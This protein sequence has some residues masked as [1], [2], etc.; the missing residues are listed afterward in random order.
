[1]P[2]LPRVTGRELA[3]ALGKLGWVVASPSLRKSGRRNF[4]PSP[5]RPDVKGAGPAA[6]LIGSSPAPGGTVPRVLLACALGSGPSADAAGST[7][8]ADQTPHAGRTAQHSAARA[9]AARRDAWDDAPEPSG[10]GS[11]TG[12]AILDKSPNSVASPARRLVI[13]A[14]YSL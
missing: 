12:R 9:G 1:M 6:C 4:W 5:S 10:Y 14:I 7:R 11:L 3:R 13:E 8:K 2:P